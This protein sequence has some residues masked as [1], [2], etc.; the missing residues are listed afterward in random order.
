VSHRW[1]G[2]RRVRQTPVLAGLGFRCPSEIEGRAGA[3]AERRGI[4]HADAE[5]HDGT[6][7]VRGRPDAGQWRRERRCDGGAGPRPRHRGIDPGAGDFRTRPPA[8]AGTDQWLDR[9]PGGGLPPGGAVGAQARG[10]AGPGLVRPLR[11]LGGARQFFGGLDDTRTAPNSPTCRASPGNSGSA[12][13]SE[14]FLGRSV[15][16]AEPSGGTE[17]GD[18]TVGSVCCPA[19]V[20]ERRSDV[21]VRRCHRD[22]GLRPIPPPRLTRS[23]PGEEAAPRPPSPAE[24]ERGRRSAPTK[25]FELGRHSRR[26]RAARGRSARTR[27]GSDL[28]ERSPAGGV[29]AR[30]GSQVRKEAS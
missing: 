22:R 24:S 21:S 15:G 18:P 6:S 26:R 12:P 17:G 30:D 14:D 7:D 29:S 28:G 5:D 8:A 13:E 10:G 1:V 11:D 25:P 2:R 16:P 3:L 19:W 23:V 4:R 20:A 9:G 27:A